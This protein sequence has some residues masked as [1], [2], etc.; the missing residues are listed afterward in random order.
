MPQNREL[1]F[2]AATFTILL[3]IIF[4]ANAVAIKISLAGLGIFTT[5]GIRFT[6][7]ALAIFVWAKWTGK[8]FQI[9][10]SRVGSLL[11]VC[12]SFTLQLALFYMGLNQTNASRATL[13][14]NLLPFFVLFL[15]HF[16]IPGDRINHRKFWGIVLGFAGVVFVFLDWQGLASAF[17]IG[18][19][20]VLAAALL[21]SGNIIYIKTIIDDFEP[22][23]LVLYP[24]IFAV[25]FYSIGALLW[26][27][28]MISRIDPWIVGAILYQSLITAGFGFVAWNTMLQRY[29][30]VSLHSFVFIMPIAGVCL[31]GLI[32]D[33]P[34][35]W[36]ILVALAL[37]TTG[38][39]VVQYRPRRVTPVLPLGRGY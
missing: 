7:A 32:L 16:F 28:P 1:S 13:M 21:W 15:A 19:S 2:L 22:F 24:M 35:T 5:A 6:I 36:N 23:H 25:P 4:G 31:G 18:D 33:E 26:D 39:L 34:L 8:S 38:I 29:G 17:R 3:C 20:I 9:K 11:I 27:Q 10:K 37:I 14:V 12:V 30:A